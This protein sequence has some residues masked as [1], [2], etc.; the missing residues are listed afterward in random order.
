VSSGARA[1]HRNELHPL[2]NH[3]TRLDSEESMAGPLLTLFYSSAKLADDL[4]VWLSA[5]KAAAEQPQ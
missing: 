4:Q 1:V 2:E 3:A 5:I